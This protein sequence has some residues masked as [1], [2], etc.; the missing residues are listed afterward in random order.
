MRATATLSGDKGGGALSEPFVRLRAYM[1]P[2]VVRHAFI[3][4]LLRALP[5]GQPVEIW[6]DHDPVP[7]RYQLDA[8]QPGQFHYEPGESREGWW[9]ATVTRV[10][11]ADDAGIRDRRP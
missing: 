1:V 6:N 4:H 7:I 10:R 8:E 2:P 5:V 3:F 9:V 11:A